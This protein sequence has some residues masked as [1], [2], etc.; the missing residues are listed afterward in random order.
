MTAFPRPILIS[1][2]GVGAGRFAAELLA[3]RGDR[4]FLIDR[5]VN[6]CQAVA[7]ATGGHPVA[8]DV[9]DQAI[10]ERAVNAAVLAGGGL[11]A[12][13]HAIRLTDGVGLDAIRAHELGAEFATHVASLLT[14]GTAVLRAMALERRGVL[15]RIDTALVD[16]PA[17]VSLLRAA[18][19]VAWSEL[20]RAAAEQGAVVETLI[21]E[22]D[23]P[24]VDVGGRIAMRLDELFSPHAAGVRQ[25]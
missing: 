13:V 16:P 9:T 1:G 6:R 18:Q 15:L 19:E 5:D 2:A 10:V 22:P 21:V 23:E 7:M 3:E 14:L 24:P 8:G 20:A 25:P 12:L 11:S 4:L 17:S